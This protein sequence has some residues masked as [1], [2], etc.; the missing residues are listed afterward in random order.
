[1]WRVVSPPQ[2]P[3]VAIPPPSVN[4]GYSQRKVSVVMPLHNCP[5]SHRLLKPRTMPGRPVL[6]LS[7]NCS[8]SYLTRCFIEDV[9]G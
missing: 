9:N 1:M 4:I 2:T 6:P 8:R 7:S 5:W 3:E